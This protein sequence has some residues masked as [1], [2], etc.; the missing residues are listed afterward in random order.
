MRVKF[1]AL[2]ILT[3]MS[4]F[5]L[6]QTFYNNGAQVGVL[7]GAVMIVK[8]GSG[9]NDGSLENATANGLLK[10]KGQITIEGSFVNSNAIADGY[11]A[12]TGEYIVYKDWVNNGTFNADQS[13]VFLRGNSQLIT[14]SSVTTFYDL[15]CETPASLKTQTIDANVSNTLTLNSNELAT[16]AYKMTVLNPDP[17]AIIVNGVTSAFVSSTGNGRLVRYT[18]SINDYLFPTG[19]NNLGTPVIREASIAPSDASG[20]IYE[21]R[22]ALNSV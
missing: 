4:G 14:G 9:A 12:N 2:S 10:N 21:V 22:M 13:T 11:S 8:T 17:N 19:W 20:R 5:I 16:D 6:G 18:N 15:E 7:D 3:L 1:L